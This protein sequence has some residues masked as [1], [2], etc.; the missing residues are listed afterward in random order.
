MQPNKI[1]KKKIYNQYT[2]K[3]LLGNYAYRL[4]ALQNGTY[5]VGKGKDSITRVD[6]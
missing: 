3:V 2:I 4:N 6:Q 5:R 1:K